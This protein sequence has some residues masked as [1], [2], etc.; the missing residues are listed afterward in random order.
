M[1]IYKWGIEFFDANLGSFKNHGIKLARFLHLDYL[2]ISFT[3]RSYSFHYSSILNGYTIIYLGF[4]TIIF[5]KHSI[6]NE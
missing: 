1:I 3:R 2:L 6:Y 4:I 5:E